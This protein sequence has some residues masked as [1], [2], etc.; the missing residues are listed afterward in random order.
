VVEFT[1]SI[2]Y[3]TD[4]GA[5]ESS[6]GWAVSMAVSTSTAEEAVSC[7]DGVESR[8]SPLPIGHPKD[9]NHT[10]QDHLIVPPQKRMAR[11]Q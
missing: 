5:A 11:L 10:Q 4:E 9:I 3:E 1:Y 2:L 7:D 6:G 8:P